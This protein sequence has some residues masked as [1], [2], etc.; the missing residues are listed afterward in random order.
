[1]MGDT[2][3]YLFAHP[4]VPF[5]LSK[6]IFDPLMLLVQA[7]QL[8]DAEVDV[9]DSVVD[10]VQSNVLAGTAAADIDP[11]MLPADPAVAANQ[12]LLVV[13]RILQRREFGWHG[14]RGW[15]IP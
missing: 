3:C 9:P 4:V 12:A 10:F 5:H 11:G 15:H 1:M 14:P 8:D 7:S 13:G 6:P 2:L